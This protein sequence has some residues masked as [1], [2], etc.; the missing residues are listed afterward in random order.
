MSPVRN[1]FD[2]T[3]ERLRAGGELGLFP[4]LTVGFP[5]PATCS[6]LLEAIAAAGADGLEMGVPFSDPLADGVTLQR[7]SAR[8]LEYGAGVGD[9]LDL[10]D[11]LRQRHQ[12]PV[13]LMS[14]VN[15]LLAY[16]VD[17]FC[18][19]GAAAGLDAVIVPDLPLEE[20]IVFQRAC[21]DHGL[22]YV[23]MVA[24]TSGP[25]RLV[26]VGER[27]AGFVY[28]VALVGTTGARAGLSAE[29]PEF[30]ANARRAIRAP[31]VAGFGISTSAHV[32][33]LARLG[34]LDG[35]IVASALAD[36]IE[37]TEPAEVE[38][39]VSAYVRELKKATRSQATLSER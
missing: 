24:P 2:S 18:R 9:A 15:P 5:D 37:R 20:S 38:A 4:Y 19:D 17:R 12:I 14:Y 25:E 33:E 7:A 32:A 13:S 11:Q 21:V 10:V 28:C 22:H 1:R 34:R 35:A 23:Y 26:A 6:R 16:G 39:A 36:L 29:L 3:F 31:L 27:A 8:A 30:L